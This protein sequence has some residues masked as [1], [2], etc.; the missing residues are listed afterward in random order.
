MIAE[1]ARHGQHSQDAFAYPDAA[2]RFDV[3]CFGRVGGFVIVGDSHGGASLVEEAVGVGGYFVGYRSSGLG[4]LFFLDCLLADCFIDF[5]GL[6]LRL[7]VRDDN[8]ALAS[9]ALAA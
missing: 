3:G 1:T 2:G 5:F 6:L 8:T 4:N 7:A 9:P